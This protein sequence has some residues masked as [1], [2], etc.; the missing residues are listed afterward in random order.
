MKRYTT[1]IIVLALAASVL[2]FFFR[3]ESEPIDSLIHAPAQDGGN[4]QIWNV[5][6]NSIGEKYLLKTPTD[7]THRS[8]IVY[9]DLN[10]DNS[11]EV[12]VFYS[13]ESANDSVCMQILTQDDDGWKFSAGLKSGFSEVKQVEFADFDGDGNLEIVVGWGLQKNNIM[14]QLDVYEY[15]ERE[16][17]LTQLFDEK[18]LSFGLF[19]FDRNGRD[20]IALITSD[21][22][23]EPVIQKLNLFSFSGTTFDNVAKMSID[24]SITT[25]SCLSFDNYKRENVSRVYIDGYTADGL[26][27]TD[28]LTFDPT[29]SILSRC[30]IGGETPSAIAKRSINVFCADIDDDGMVEIP[31]NRKVET[32]V[33]SF[34][35]IE[36]KSV[37]KN[38][39]VTVCYYYDNR[40]NGYYFNIP[41][42]IVNISYPSVSSDGSRLWFYSSVSESGNGELLFEIV[43]DNDDLVSPISTQYRLLESHKGNNYYC[44]ITDAGSDLGI[45]KKVVSSSLIFV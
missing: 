41:E 38:K 10:F 36:W 9:A 30:Y 6:E 23:A 8:A 4:G 21:V 22:S 35:L 24:P 17:S 14:Q 43:I 29:S 33:S 11:D 26:L 1:A 37:L 15:N 19:D 18:Y 12:I 45:T 31:V 39:T 3:S 42:S 40:E 2:L 28:L 27:S 32:K 34:N 5:L 16:N 20:E 7:G 25:V 13:T 44:H